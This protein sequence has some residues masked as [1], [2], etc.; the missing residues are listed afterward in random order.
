[1]QSLLFSALCL[2]GIVEVRWFFLRRL[3]E[4]YMQF[5]HPTQRSSQEFW[6]LLIPPVERTPAKLACGPSKSAILEIDKVV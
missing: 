1:M 2:D 6:T 4:F 5:E 3:S